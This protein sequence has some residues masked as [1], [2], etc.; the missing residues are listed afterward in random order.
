MTG[1]AGFIGSHLTEELV[2]RGATTRAMVHYNSAGSRGWLDHSA[3]KG[4]IEIV[5]GE[6]AVLPLC[7]GLPWYAL[8]F[9]IANLAVL[10]VR[11]RAEKAAFEQI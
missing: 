5:A 4:N 6:I 10:G 2:R 1:A 8:V 3:V 11:I 7:L 9:S